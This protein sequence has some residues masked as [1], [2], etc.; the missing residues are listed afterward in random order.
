MERAIE[1]QRTEFSNREIRLAGHLK[2][3]EFRD[4]LETRLLLL[5]RRLDEK[6]LP[7]RL[8]RTARGLMHLDMAGGR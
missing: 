2:L 8:R 1:E 5:R 6:E 4:N 7:I 3:P